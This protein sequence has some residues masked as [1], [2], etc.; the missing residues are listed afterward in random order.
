MNRSDKVKEP[1][2]KLQNIRKSYSMGSQELQVLKGIDLE[3]YE[4]DFLAILGPSGSGKSTIMNII[5][6][7]DSPTSGKYIFN[8]AEVSFENDFSLSKIR[9]QTIGFI[10]QKFNLLSKFNALENVEM[11]LLIR[12][13]TRKSANPH[14]V[15]ALES[16]DL[17][18]RM[19][20]K[21]VELSGG[22]Q[23]RVAVAR[24]LAANPSILLADEPTG[25]LDSKSESDIM[26]LFKKLNQEGKT[27]IL[28]THSQEVASIC[29]R[30]I[31]IKDG[32]IVSSK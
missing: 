32:E 21:P 23:Q 9:N 6:L 31:T 17:L 22:Q 27:I 8:G 11:P 10:F 7:I 3:I 30:V 26:E 14:A 1:I 4:G 28:I 20:H 25:N 24:A 13:Y 16:V 2:I 5:G 15:K 19:L 18:D 12:G 29:T